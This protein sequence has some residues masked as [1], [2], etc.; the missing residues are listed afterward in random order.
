MKKNILTILILSCFSLNMIECR[1]RGGVGRVGGY[2]R[3]G[4]G[5]VGVGHGGGHYGGYGGYGYGAAGLGIGL[6][7]AG[8]IASSEAYNNSPDV[9]IEE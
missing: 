9:V 5:R 4:V 6:G 8:L 3:G 7:A 2:G 1:G